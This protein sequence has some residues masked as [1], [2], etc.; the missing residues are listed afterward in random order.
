MSAVIVA[1]IKTGSSTMRANVVM[2]RGIVFA[3]MRVR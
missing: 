3:C 1:A 2:L